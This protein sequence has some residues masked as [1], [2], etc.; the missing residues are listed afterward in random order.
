MTDEMP[1]LTWRSAHRNFFRADMSYL[2]PEEREKAGSHLSS[3]A[4]SRSRG[5]LMYKH[6]LPCCQGKEHR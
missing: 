4:G 1:R 5:T 3:V 2:W 6:I